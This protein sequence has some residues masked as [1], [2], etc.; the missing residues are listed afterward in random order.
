MTCLP[1]LSFAAVVDLAK[2]LQKRLFYDGA[3]VISRNRAPSLRKSGVV[4]ESEELHSSAIGQTS[5]DVGHA[6]NLL[7][8]EFL[9]DCDWRAENITFRERGRRWS[10]ALLA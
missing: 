1:N 8:D 3:G 5:R 10:P 4:W 9:F 2:R 6:T 7:N